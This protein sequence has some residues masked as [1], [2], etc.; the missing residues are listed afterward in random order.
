VPVRDLESVEL[1][2]FTEAPKIVRS[3]GVIAAPRSVVF[4]KIADDPA[5]WGDWFPGFNHDGR[6]ET[7]EPHG[8]GSVRTVRAFRTD[9]RETVLAWDVNERWAFR[10]DATGSGMFAAFAEDYRLTDEGSGTRLTWTVAFRPG[11]VMKVVGPLAA[12]T[13]H[14]VARRVVAGLN[15]VTS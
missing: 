8:V 4:A 1:P 2:F 12:P 9:Y 14:L 5:G 6:W 13:L 11:T 7:P 15:R 10:V 3:E